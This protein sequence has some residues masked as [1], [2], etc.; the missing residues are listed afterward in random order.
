MNKLFEFITQALSNSLTNNASTRRV[1]YFGFATLAAIAFGFGLGWATSL[2]V[3]SASVQKYM[4][5]DR[6]LSFLEYLFVV[7]MG[8]T[9]FVYGATKVVEL[10]GK[11]GP[12]E[13]KPSE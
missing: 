7:G 11:G 2:V 13:A 5:F 1:V 3:A 10:R 12:N 8:T 6:S 4:F 9:G